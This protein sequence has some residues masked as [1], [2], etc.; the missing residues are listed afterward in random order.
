MI[1]KIAESQGLSALWGGTVGQGVIPGEVLPGEDPINLEMDEDGKYKGPEP[2]TGPGPDK[3][4][5][6]A[7]LVERKHPPESTLRAHVEYKKLCVKKAGSVEAFEAVAAKQFDSYWAAFLNS[8]FMKPKKKLVTEWTETDWEAWVGTWKSLAAT[9][10]G[11]SKTT[12]FL[13][14]LN[15]APESVKE[16]HREKW[17]RSVMEKHVKGER[18]PLDPPEERESLPEEVERE[19]VD[20]GFVDPGLQP[21]AHTPGPNASP[22]P[23]KKSVQDL[24]AER[25]NLAMEINNRFAVGVVRHVMGILNLEFSLQDNIMEDLK[26]RTLKEVKDIF[27]ELEKGSDDIPF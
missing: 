4:I 2:G 11:K 23:K 15:V 27:A 22:E 26:T 5:T 16:A 10:V 12:Q 17:C 24:M 25:D 19:I 21:P 14:I 18:W 6:F 3:A 8:S 1:A 13:D 9:F 7:T 20:E